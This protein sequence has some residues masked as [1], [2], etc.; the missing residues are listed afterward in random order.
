VGSACLVMHRWSAEM[1]QRLRDEEIQRVSG[2][3]VA[4]YKV[5]K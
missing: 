3:N 4:R 5:G 2:G 1:A